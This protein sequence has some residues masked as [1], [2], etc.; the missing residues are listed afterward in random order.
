MASHKIHVPVSTKQIY[1][2]MDFP[3]CHVRSD[4]EQKVRQARHTSNCDKNV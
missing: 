2:M 3:A 1:G 4:V